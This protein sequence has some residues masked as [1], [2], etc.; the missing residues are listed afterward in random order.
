MALSDVELMGDWPASDWAKWSSPE[1][2]REYWQWALGD[3]K[4]SI[5]ILVHR[6]H[7]DLKAKAVPK[8]IDNLVRSAIENTTRY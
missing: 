7:A 6:V 8:E 1:D 3:Y 2:W 4:G 5:P